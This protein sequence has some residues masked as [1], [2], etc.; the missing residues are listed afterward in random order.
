[1]LGTRPNNVKPSPP[2]V[3]RHEIKDP[4][5]GGYKFGYLA[6]DQSESGNFL[7]K[8]K[9]LLTGQDS[10]CLVIGRVVPGRKPTDIGFVGYPLV[11]PRLIVEQMAELAYRFS[12]TEYYMDPKTLDWF[13]KNQF[14]ANYCMDRQNDMVAEEAKAISEGKEY[15]ITKNYD[16][17]LLKIIRHTDAAFRQ[18]EFRA[19]YQNGMIGLTPD[20]R[21]DNNFISDIEDIKKPILCEAI[22]GLLLAANRYR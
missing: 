3:L 10:A 8:V 22:G 21:N 20:L 9:R 5:A 4:F 18:T 2:P 16:F 13:S 12:I 6:I 11:D 19:A 17:S 14:F 7:E 1:M 15:K